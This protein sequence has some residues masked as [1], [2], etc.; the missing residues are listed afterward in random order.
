MRKLVFLYILVAFIKNSSAQSIH[1][2][3]VADVADP[4][5]AMVSNRGQAQITQIFETIASNLKYNYNPPIYI[6]RKQF[7]SN[8]IKEK[9]T[10]LKTQPNDIIVFFYSGKAYYPTISKSEYPFF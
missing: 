3:M 2:I 8:T 9:I 10:A 7:D 6:T 1:L 5:F 4:N